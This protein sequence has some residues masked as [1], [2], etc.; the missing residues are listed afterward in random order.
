MVASAC[1]GLH[2]QAHEGFGRATR[3]V[4]KF[5]GLTSEEEVLVRLRGVRDLVNASTVA[6]EHYVINAMLRDL[7]FGSHQQFVN[8]PARGLPNVS[9]T[10]GSALFYGQGFL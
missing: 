10:L 8:Y 6:E 3:L 7:A 9:V 1:W 5:G 4:V 2:L